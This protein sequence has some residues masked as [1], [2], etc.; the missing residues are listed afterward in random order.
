[1][2]STFAIALSLVGASGP[3]QG[4]D[5]ILRAFTQ[6]AVARNSEQMREMLDAWDEGGFRTATEAAA[7]NP[8]CIPNDTVT[9]TVLTSAFNLDRGKLRGMAAESLLK[10]SKTVAGLAPL[11]KAT[12]YGAAWSTVTGRVRAVDEM[13]MCVAAIDPAGIRTLL[14]T[15]PDSVAQRRAIG[16]LTPSLGNC[17]SAGFQL[18]AKPASLR[19][20]LAEA[21]YHR[22]TAEAGG[23]VKVS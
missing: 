15:A 23:R 14:A 12:N 5:Q 3:T 11:A 16:T 10:R 19:A 18:D 6:C 7:T 21:L 13:A 9:T 22:D 4:T 8:R 20:A 17:L 1:M 2:L